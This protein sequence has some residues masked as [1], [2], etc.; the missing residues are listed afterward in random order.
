MFFVLFSI[1][2]GITAGIFPAIFFAKMNAVQ[3]LKSMSTVPVFKGITVRK[4]LITFQYSISIISICATLIIYKQYKHFLAYDL[5][6]A[7]ENIL[8]IRLQGNKAELLKKELMELPEVKGISQSMLI[9]GLGYFWNTGMKNPSDP[10]DSALVNY[11]IIDENYLSLHNY[12]FLAG[13]NFTGKVG[14]SEENEVIV[15]HQVLRRFN[16][17]GQDPAKAIGEIIKVDN[18]ALRIIGVLK[19]F[20]F[21]RANSQGRKEV[22]MRYAN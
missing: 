3:I 14:R 22:I 6:F 10:K 20:E 21:V 1:L 18:K 13:G 12:Q 11:N 9:S 7:T 16:I 5:G 15:N 19:D 8:N 4:V 17:T 2:V